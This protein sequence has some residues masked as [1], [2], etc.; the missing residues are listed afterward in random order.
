M[1]EKKKFYKKP[2]LWI[3]LAI[4][5]GIG[6]AVGGIESDTPSQKDE[7]A[8]QEQKADEKEK[9]KEEK[10]KED[11]IAKEEESKDKKKADEKALAKEYQEFIADHSGR[12]SDNMFKFSD[13]MLNADLMS[14]DWIIKAAVTFLETISLC[15]EALNYSQEKVPDVFREF[16]SIYTEAMKKYKYV[17]E[18]LPSAIDNQDVARMEELNDIMK[19]AT[20]LIEDAAPVLEKALQAASSM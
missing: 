15:D 1:N 5:F 18:E 9:A 8:K 2:W 6:L 19:E 11:E 16:H 14:Q 4:V 7:T 17:A 13:V 10:K 3:I 12:F 20:K